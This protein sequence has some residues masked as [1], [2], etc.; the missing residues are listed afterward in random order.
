MALTSLS[1]KP[2]PVSERKD[3]FEISLS[4]QGCYHLEGELSFASVELA[5]KKT[6]KIF[7]SPARMVFDLAGVSKVDS[8]GLALLL[9][10]LRQARAVGVELHYTHLPRQL[11][12]MAEV[13]G[14][15]EI[16]IID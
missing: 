2:A 15:D 1:K 12:A 14:V 6:E 4:G 13:V 16:L 8:A 9:E 3:A 7:V 11:M 10:W 5:L